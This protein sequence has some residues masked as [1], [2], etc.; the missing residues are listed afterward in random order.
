MSRTKRATKVLA[1][2]LAFVMVLGIAVPVLAA[3][4]NSDLNGNF[5]TFVIEGS[6]GTV[7]TPANVKEV[8]LEWRDM[9]GN[10]AGS[11]TLAYANGV[12]VVDAAS[13]PANVAQGTTTRFFIQVFGEDGQ[14]GT[15]VPAMFI[16][17]V[18]SINV[19]GSADGAVAYQDFTV[20][21]FDP[22]GRPMYTTVRPLVLTAPVINVTEV[23]VTPVQ[24]SAQLDGF[25]KFQDYEAEIRPANA[26]NRQVAWSIDAAAT[27]N[28]ATI[29]PLAATV[30]APGQAN[31]FRARLSIPGVNTFDWVAGDSVDV[32]AT[33]LN[34]R[35]DT[36]T[37]R[38]RP[39]ALVNRPNATLQ[40]VNME[41]SVE[42]DLDQIRDMFAS[43]RLQLVLEK[44]TGGVNAE[45]RFRDLTRTID[46][47]QWDARNG[48]F[49]FWIDRDDIQEG[50]RLVIRYFPQGRT[51]A[52][53]NYSTKVVYVFGDANKQ[54]F[55][56]STDFLYNTARNYIQV[57]ENGTPLAGVRMTVEVFRAD[58]T[59]VGA[60]TTT[61]TTNSHGYFWY[62]DYLT[63]TPGVSRADLAT[64]GGANAT[65][66]RGAI[67]VRND[68]GADINVPMG[69]YV[70][71]TPVQGDVNRVG[72]PFIRWTADNAVTITPVWTR[73]PNPTTGVLDNWTVRVDFADYVVDY[74]ARTV[75]FRIRAFT[76]G[77]PG[78]QEPVVGS[79]FA[80]YEADRDERLY[81]TAGK[82]VAT[83]KTDEN[84]YLEIDVEVPPMVASFT[85][86]TASNYE[87]NYIPFVL[88]QLDGG[89]DI[90]VRP[91]AGLISPEGYYDTNGIRSGNNAWLAITATD[92][93]VNIQVRNTRDEAF[94]IEGAD[95]YAN[96]VEVAKAM[97]P[98]GLVY[99]EFDTYKD[100]VVA[101]SQDDKL[102]DALTAGSV[103]SVFDGPLLVIDGKTI[104]A[105]VED[106]I[107]TSGA[108]RIIVVGGP[109]TISDDVVTKLEALSASVLRI[110]G[111]NRY[112]TAVEAAKKVMNATGGD[113][114]LLAN[115]QG[116]DKFVDALTVSAVAGEWGFPVILT[117]A[118]KLP[119]ESAAFLSNNDVANVFVIGGVNTVSEEVVRGIN[120]AVESGTTI[121]RVAGDNRFATAVEI[122]KTFFDDAEQAVFVNG[123]NNQLALIAGPFAAKLDGPVL[124]VN[125]DN[126][127]A[128]VAAYLP[129][130][131]I[132]SGVVVG[133]VASVSEAVRLELGKLMRD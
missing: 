103:A 72:S 75:T 18:V 6:N 133:D 51:V 74:G 98:N 76:E 48:E 19:Y 55:R 96:A 8:I 95:I 1:L 127:P 26:T 45:D 129:T 23:I 62:N 57:V 3:P 130:S 4:I 86:F 44:T 79:T 132:D 121:E 92:R 85:G 15:D 61:R 39:E 7:A 91:Y 69:G 31:P 49:G 28:G 71:F 54:V 2:V 66:Q 63:V 120:A 59:R 37:F 122:A 78:S 22:A 124:L 29:A 107:R 89:S 104:P 77:R 13:L 16:R 52:P 125:A 60:F 88:K 10:P 112:E 34:G 116:N 110:S 33:A 36:E 20:L 81:M 12:W 32:T 126:V 65:I 106:Y 58:N 123:F 50:D 38:L 40:F 109:S 46:W 14:I 35:F 100:I 131:D 70:K 101:T 82:Q 30:V 25:D 64:T 118:D 128:E 111:D 17:D 80:V 87:F 119:K 73:D 117:E 27:A 99:G 90:T 102:A 113:S 68:Q 47:G 21:G 11:S 43:D 41:G 5:F 53:N 9:D 93:V 42:F 67:V 114:V 56:V 84:G 24:G 108:T 97:Y 94:R 83:G 105:V 115:G